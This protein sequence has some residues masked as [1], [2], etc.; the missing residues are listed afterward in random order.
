[1]NLIFLFCDSSKP[2]FADFEAWFAIFNFVSCELY[3]SLMEANE[4]M[5]DF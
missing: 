3:E 5:N 2:F 1:M 4:V